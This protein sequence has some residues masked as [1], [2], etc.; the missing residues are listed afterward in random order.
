[1]NITTKPEELATTVSTLVRSIIARVA[2]TGALRLSI[3]RHTA[4]ILL[5]DGVRCYTRNKNSPDDEQHRRTTSERGGQNNR[6][7]NGPGCHGCLPDVVHQLSH[8]R[9]HPNRGRAAEDVVGPL[10]HGLG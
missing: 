1:M 8:N 5:V 4:L 2:E 3:P 7:I 10:M 9:T 6:C